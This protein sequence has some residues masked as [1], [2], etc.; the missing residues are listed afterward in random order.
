MTTNFYFVETECQE[1]DSSTSSSAVNT[2]ASHF[3]NKRKKCDNAAERRHKE[4]MQ[5]QDRYLDIL[6]QIAESLD[7]KN[8]ENKK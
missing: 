3:M 6:Q 4:K 2:Y 7:K 5:R 8:T 1:S